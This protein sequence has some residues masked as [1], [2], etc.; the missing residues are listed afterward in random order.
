MDPSRRALAV[1][2]A[3]AAGAAGQSPAPAELRS[4]FYPFESLP[5]RGTGKSRSRAVLRGRNRKGITVEIHHTELAPGA[6]PHPPHHHVHEEIIVVREGLM[7]VTIMGRTEKLGPG[8][9]AWVASNEEHG[10][11]NAGDTQAH[12]VVLALGIGDP[13]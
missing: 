4:G 12:Y 6:E 7:E 5:V 10:W 9:I 3:T 1:L 11:H 13:A 8:G 2:L